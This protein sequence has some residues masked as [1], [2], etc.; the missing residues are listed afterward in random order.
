MLLEQYIQQ[1]KKIYE[2]KIGVAG[3]QSDDFTDKLE[4]CLQ[5]YGLLKLSP[6]KKTPLQERPLDFP[7][8]KNERVTYFEAE[9]EYPTTTQ[10]L[11]DYIS[12]CC[13]CQE[14][15]VLVRNAGDMQEMYQ[16][17][18]DGQKVYQSKLETEEL[19]SADPKAQ[20]HVGGNRVMSLLAEL[21]KAR[22]EREIDP[23][24]GAPKGESSDISEDGNNKSAIGS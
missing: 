19:E 2:F 14:G 23:V 18:L 21:E 24:K 15:M 9:L 5:K 1:A 6:G 16:E 4:S 17:E 8:L 3:E 12:N 20:D 13:D 7:N 10:V 11:K 22:T